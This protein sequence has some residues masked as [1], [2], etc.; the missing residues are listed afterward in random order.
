MSIKRSETYAGPAGGAPDI[1][2]VRS[3]RSARLGKPPIKLLEFLPVFGFGGTER[4]VVNLACRL[5]R[6]RFD[7]T[8][9]C[10]KRWGQFLTD[11]EQQQI[12]VSEYPINSLYKPATFRRQLQLAVD[13]RRG[14]IQIVHS[15]NFYANVFAV[16]SA[17]LAGAPVV[18][19][20]V[21]DTGMG[22]TPAKMR[23]HK[24]ACRLAD[25]IVVNAEAIRQW[26]VD[27]GYR[28]E[29]IEVIH[30]GVDLSRFT[31][32]AEDEG[33][34]LRDELG[35]PGDGPLVTVLARLAPP[36]GIEFFLEAA[37]EV[38]RHHPQ[39][40]FL[41]VGDVRSVTRRDGVTERDVAYYRRLTQY[42]ACLGLD[43]RVVFT[44]YRP[45]IPELLS[46]AAVSVLP[47]ISGEGLPNALM[48]A[49]AAGVP[50]VGTRV[51]GTAEVVG[52]SGTA[53]LLVP[54]RDPRSLA[55]AI[56]ALLEDGPMA[57]RLGEQARRRVQERFSLERMV[58][59]TEDLYAG[60]LD[61]K[62]RAGGRAWRRFWQKSGHVPG[63]QSGL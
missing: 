4:Q 20:S 35:V 5:D 38:S 27:Q 46:Q 44:G 25:C 16:P 9:A 36:K 57:R 59:E 19:A 33:R 14:G 31:P 60:L 53:G 34:R 61:A 37:A 15:Y 2:S 17:R 10:M 56:G 47:S 21:R 58:R 30:N 54:P 18:I 11:I 26:L 42:A 13:I 63:S 28:R 12:P 41:V 62:L 48:E 45:D 29:N 55:Q 40:R 22:M 6:S 32:L 1:D 52:E 51:G 43:E 39:A 50:V 7:L 3:P 8:F 49:M 24:V 23:L